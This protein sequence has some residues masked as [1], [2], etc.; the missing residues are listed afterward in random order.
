[1]FL[2]TKVTVEMVVRVLGKWINIEHSRI[3]EK[4]VNL[5]EAIAPTNEYI[6]FWKFIWAIPDSCP[7]PHR[8]I[9]PILKNAAGGAKNNK[10]EK[11][12]FVRIN[13]NKY[14]TLCRKV[15][16]T[17]YQML[18]PPYNNNNFSCYL[19][20]YLYNNLTLAVT[21]YKPKIK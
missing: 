11:K 9:F 12:I 20:F 10:I 18:P 3:N 16:Y 4:R 14:L 7:N 8:S 2:A 1:M 6:K 13:V 15:I 17:L 21:K 19:Y 5:Q